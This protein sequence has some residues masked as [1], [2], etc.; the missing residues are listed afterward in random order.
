MNI[1]MWKRNLITRSVT[2]LPSLLVVLLVGTNGADALIVWSQVILSIQLPFALIPLLKMTGN[3]N[4]MGETFR[5]SRL[6]Q[7]CGW[8]IGGMIIVANVTLIGFSFQEYLDISTVAG[9][10]FLGVEIVVGLCYLV[11]LIY[12]ATVPVGN[13]STPPLIFGEEE[14]SFERLAINTQKGDP[15]ALYESA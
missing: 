13:N 1:A 14:S 5:N 12:L 9:R 3:S 8:I 10:V 4:V 11:F 15:L 2:I 7:A 6:L